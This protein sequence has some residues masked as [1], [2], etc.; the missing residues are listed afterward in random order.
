[1]RWLLGA[2]DSAPNDGAN[3]LS[4]WIH[5]ESHLQNVSSIYIGNTVK[6]FKF[7]RRRV[8]SATDLQSLVS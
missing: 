1:M 2:V 4:L 6:K 3:V 7:L 8:I 5:S